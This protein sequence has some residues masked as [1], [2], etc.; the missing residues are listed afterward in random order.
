MGDLKQEKQHKS[1]GSSRRY[2][3]MRIP[4]YILDSQRQPANFDTA[5]PP[6]TPILVFVNSRSGGQLGSA[7][8]KSFRI[9]LNPKQVFDLADGKP[10]EVLRHLLGHL[11]E[12]K[13][14]GDEFAMHVRT[15]MRIVVS[16]L[17]FLCFFS[18]RPLC[19]FCCYV[20]DY[21]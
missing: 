16:F 18:E 1:Q 12:L 15:H 3:A 17:L 14:E 19:C 4:D 13:E 2:E 9:V 20:H 11:E 7:I 8:I 5:N 21:L 6:E 10:E